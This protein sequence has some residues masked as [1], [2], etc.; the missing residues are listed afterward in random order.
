VEMIK[1]GVMTI[2]RMTVVITATEN[3]S[4]PFDTKLYSK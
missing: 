4:T 3:N 1:T 2:K